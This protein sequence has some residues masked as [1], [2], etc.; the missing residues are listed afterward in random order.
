[1]TAIRNQRRKAGESPRAAILF[2][3]VRWF[4][5]VIM[6]F[7][8]LFPIFWIMSGSLKSTGEFYTTPPTFLPK[9]IVWENYS[10]ALSARGAKGLLD[11]V[12]VGVVVTLL[13]MAISIPASYSI[14]RYSPGGKQIS[15]FI[16]SIL[17]LPP[18]I[19]VIPLFFIFKTLKLLD[20][21]YVLFISYMFF[22][23]PFSI[24]IMKGFFEDIPV[25][26]EQATMMDGFSRFKVFF[27]ISIPLARAGIAVA[28][29]FAFIFSW[30]ELMFASIFGRNAVQTLPLALQ[31][32]IGSTGVAWGELSA[33]GTIAA[34]PG[35]L[36]AVL[37]QKYIVRG[38]TFGAVKG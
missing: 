34:L 18:V 36:L 33:L 13:T 7:V 12:I 14:A 24:W 6:L 31:D 4:V 32:Y 2:G 19:G 8:F 17:F 37:M 29:L 21:Y 1:M 27:K 30:N 23:L 5:I 38:L 16:L 9:S 22:N 20:T 3:V 10:N 11:S 28:A 26:L 35:I 15:F 25:D